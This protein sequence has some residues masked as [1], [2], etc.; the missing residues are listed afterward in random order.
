MEIDCTGV[1]DQV[2]TDEDV[3]L[4]CI[5]LR[6]LGADRADIDDIHRSAR[7]ADFEA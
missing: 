7:A 6:G 4:D 5:E 2:L 3:A 1:F